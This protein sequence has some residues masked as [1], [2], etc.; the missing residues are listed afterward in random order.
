MK[1]KHIKIFIISIIFALTLSCTTFS[2]V[3]SPTWPYFEDEL[4]GEAGCVMD[5]DSGIIL[6]EKNPD[7]RMYPASITKIMTALVVFDHVQNLDDEVFFSYNACNKD[8]DRTS[9]VIGASPGDKLS[10]KDCLYAILLPSANDVANALA[11]HIAGNIKDFSLLMN[12]TAMMLGM[13]NSHFTNPSGLH[14]ENHYTTA[15]DMAIMMQY[16]SKNPIFLQISSS[17]SFTHAPRRKYKDPKNSN[18]TMLTTN[19]LIIPG[20]RYHYRYATSGK[21]G[22][23]KAAGYCL[24]ATSKK[25]NMNLVAVTLNSKKINDRFVDAKNLFDFYYKNYKSLSIKEYDDRF[26]TDYANMS[27]SNVDIVKSINITCNADAHITLPKDMN[28]SDIRSEVHFSLKD[29]QQKNAIGYI[30]YFIDDK[31]IG[32]CEIIGD[33]FDSEKINIQNLDISSIKDSIKNQNN[34][35]ILER[36][37]YVNDDLP[38]YI[39]KIGH[40]RLSKGF[41]KLLM[42]LLIVIV[43]VVIITFTYSK[44]FMTLSESIN[45]IYTRFKSK[46][47]KKKRSRKNTKFL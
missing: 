45:F 15:R 13:T 12:E 28:T 44:I 10:V 30:E 40:I 35:E 41:S 19:N 22:Y 31:K 18:N 33:S 20:S 21:T 37:A 5:A 4:L 24:V 27:I 34:I 32:E 39:D 38:I 6:Y 23:T 16:A 2:D 26:N 17:V 1:H 42:V 8:I 3:K 25:D 11:E 43:I 47:R 46:S 29:N 36:S 14:D 7:K 9:T